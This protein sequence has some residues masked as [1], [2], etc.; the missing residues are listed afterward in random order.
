MHLLVF[1]DEADPSIQIFLW[2]AG[3]E[4]ILSCWSEDAQWSLFVPCLHCVI[5]SPTGIFGGGKGAGI[6]SVLGGAGGL[7]TTAF[8]GHQKITLNSGLEMLIRN[9]GR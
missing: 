7:G 3:R 8:H 2:V 9:T 1:D 5:E 4:D 6:G